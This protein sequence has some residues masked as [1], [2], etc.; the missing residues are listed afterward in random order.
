MSVLVYMAIGITVLVN[1]FVL[2]EHFRRKRL[3]LLEIKRVEEMTNKINEA[4]RDSVRRMAANLSV[5]HDIIIEILQAEA[6][7]DLVESHALKFLRN[8][9]RHM[10][11]QEDRVRWLVGAVPKVLRSIAN[12]RLRAAENYKP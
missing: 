2:M 6:S 8:G 3:Y 1:G 5:C 4:H 10:A 9:V 12:E 11:G 7:D